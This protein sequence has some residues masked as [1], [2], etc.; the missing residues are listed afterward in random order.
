MFVFTDPM[1]ILLCVRS[2]E[3][4]SANAFVSVG[5][6]IG[7][8]VPFKRQEWQN[9]STWNSQCILVCESSAVID[10]VPNSQSRSFQN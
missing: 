3:K 9:N 5:F 2:V 7:V 8:P 10:H 1:G 6:P 4:N